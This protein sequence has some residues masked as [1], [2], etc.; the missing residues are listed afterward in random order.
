MEIVT[1]CITFLLVI[2]LCE[3]VCVFAGTCVPLW[4]GLLLRLLF[5]I[6]AIL[7]RLVRPGTVPGP[8]SSG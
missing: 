5:F 4:R 1:I 8:G 7:V 2:A 3:T 6:I